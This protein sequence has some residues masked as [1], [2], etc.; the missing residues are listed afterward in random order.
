MFFEGDVLLME[1]VE[2]SLVEGD[3]ALETGHLDAIEHVKG[4]F[5]GLFLNAIGSF[6][7]L[8]LFLH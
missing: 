1:W 4:S 6:N 3:S 7:C 8:V 2:L 5:L